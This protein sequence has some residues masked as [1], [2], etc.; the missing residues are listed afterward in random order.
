M[1]RRQ[2]AGKPPLEHTRGQTPLI[3]DPSAHQT[4]HYSRDGSDFNTRDSGVGRWCAHILQ[5]LCNGSVFLFAA[6]ESCWSKNGHLH[7]DLRGHWVNAAQDRKEMSQTRGDE[8][9][10]SRPHGGSG[11][12]PWACADTA[13][14]PW[15]RFP[16]HLRSSAMKTYNDFPLHWNYGKLLLQEGFVFRYNVSL[17]S[18]KQFWF[19]L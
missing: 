14:A 10:S 4:T 19:L 17:H 13:A 8:A 3:A 6:S 16:H 18:S 11:A 7:V 9:E 2:A 15:Q 1:I 5:L 12:L